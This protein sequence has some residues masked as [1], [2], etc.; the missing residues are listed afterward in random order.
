VPLLVA[1]LFTYC[2]KP[3]IEFQMT[4]MGLPRGVAIVGAALIALALL[5]MAGVLVVAFAAEF[6]TELRRLQESVRPTDRPDGVA[7]DRLGRCRSIASGDGHPEREHPRRAGVAGAACHEVLSFV[8]L[9]LIF[10]LFLLL[11]PARA[12][13]WPPAV[14]SPRSSRG[15][16]GYILQMVGFSILTGVLVGVSL[17]W[18]ESNSPS[19]SGSSPFC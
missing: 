5:G 9:V 10:V 12:S 11:G 14:C 18:L 8:G 4:R 3:V 17:A 6:A 7:A 1:L 2:L 19:R 16:S 13:R 15:P